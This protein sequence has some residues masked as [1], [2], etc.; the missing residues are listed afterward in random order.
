MAPARGEPALRRGRMVPRES[1]SWRKGHCLAQRRSAGAARGI[2]S[3]GDKTEV[4]KWGGVQSPGRGGSH[5]ASSSDGRDEA[6]GPLVASVRIQELNLSVWQVS[7]DRTRN[8]KLSCKAAP[9][10]VRKRSGSVYPNTPTQR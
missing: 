2:E 9:H 3:H 6:R 1:Y 10:D 4:T 7:S 8:A 5:R